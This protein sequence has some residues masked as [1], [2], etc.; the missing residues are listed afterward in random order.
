[1]H[2]IAH[3]IQLKNNKIIAAIREVNEKIQEEEAHIRNLFELN[4]TRVKGI[5]EKVKGAGITPAGAEMVNEIEEIFELLDR[6]VR[7]EEGISSAYKAVNDINDEFIE[8]PTIRF[9]SMLMG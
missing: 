2:A 8:E 9:R 7:K 5:T 4:T 6:A 3:S 1:M